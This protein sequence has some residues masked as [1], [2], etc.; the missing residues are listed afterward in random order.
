MSQEQ[1][2]GAC[3]RL[4]RCDN[5]DEDKVKVKCADCRNEYVLTQNA[6]RKLVNGGYFALAPS[7]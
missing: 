6:Y 2:R 4:V 7:G 5:G 1:C 3:R